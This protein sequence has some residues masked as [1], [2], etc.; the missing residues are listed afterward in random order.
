[1]KKALAICSAF[2]LSALA[3]AQDAAG[4]DLTTYMTTL[5]TETEN[6]VETLLPLL[7]NVAVI[8]IVIFLA[9]WAFRMV[10]RFLAGR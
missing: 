9:I 6:Q 7:G 1:M 8:G 10:K 3:L 5:T 4:L 2:G